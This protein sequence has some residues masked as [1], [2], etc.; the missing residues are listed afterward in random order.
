TQSGLVDAEDVAWP[1]KTE[2]HRLVAAGAA[3][4][5]LVGRE[6][7]GAVGEGVPRDDGAV[8]EGPEAGERGG[9]TPRRDAVR[10]F[11]L[12]DLQQPRDRNVMEPG[13]VRRGQSQ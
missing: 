2:E 6:G 4:Q 11:G 10:G 13:N 7:S 1:E 12:L 3:H 8:D 5:R 9:L